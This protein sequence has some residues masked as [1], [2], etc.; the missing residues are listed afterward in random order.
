MMLRQENRRTRVGRPLR[1]ASIPKRLLALSLGFLLV[2]C[3]ATRYSIPGTAG[4]HGLSRYVL[5]IKETPDAQ[6]THSWEPV[7]SLDLSKYPYRAINSDVQGHI[8]RVAWTRNCEDEFDACVKMCM[9][10]LRGPNWSHANRGSKAAICRDRCRPAYNDCSQLR[11]Q[12]EALRFPIIDNAV[13]WLKHHRRE[14][15]VGTVV[16]IAGVAFVV[17]VAGSGGSVLVLAPAVVLVSSDAPSE[18]QIAAANP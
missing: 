16:V 14:L 13:D 5:V 15:L 8:V 7:S 2:S 10:S 11:D 9:S 6:I 17:V 1:T 18:H 3:S 4:S 12:A